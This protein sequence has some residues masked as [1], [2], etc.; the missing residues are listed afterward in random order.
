M[1]SKIIRFFQDKEYRG[2]ADPKSGISFVPDWYKKAESKYVDPSGMTQQG[3]KTC[4]PYLDALISGYMIST[5]VNIYINQTENEIGHLFNNEEG[6]S[7]NW[8]GPMFLSD[9]INERPSASGQTM[10]RPAGHYPNH[11]VFKGYWSIKT[12]KGYSLLMTHPL[13]RHDLPFTTLSGIID[14][15]KFFAPGNIPF[16]FKKGFSGVIPKGTPIAQ[17]I[18]IK[19][20]K[21]IAYNDDP[22][23]TDKT[24][25]QTS[26]I[27]NKETNY[28]KKFWQRK[29]YQ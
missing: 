19:R 1:R 11:M 13:N 15:D 22:Y 28:K 21:W 2:L 18:P 5:P 9:F 23:L 27:D 10:P 8:D 17:L 6:L 26:Y 7:V 20:N 12:P 29:S 25:I 3:L 16:F 24:M 4:M 14:S